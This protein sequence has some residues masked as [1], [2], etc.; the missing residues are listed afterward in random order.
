MREKVIRPR[1]LETSTQI[2]NKQVDLSSVELSQHPDQSLLGL[3]SKPKDML[4][5]SFLINS[6]QARRLSTRGLLKPLLFKVILM[7][8]VVSMVV[9]ATQ[10]FPLSFR[11][12]CQ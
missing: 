6:L 3:P 9:V 11:L 10:L 12:T 5:V 8:Q 7:N 2:Y 4:L 1:Y